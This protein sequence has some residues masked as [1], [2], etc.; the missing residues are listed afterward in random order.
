MHYLISITKLPKQSVHVSQFYFNHLNHLNGWL[1]NDHGP[2]V[3]E[4]KTLSLN[5]VELLSGHKFFPLLLSLTEENLIVIGDY[6]HYK[7]IISQNEL[8]EAQV[9]N[10]FI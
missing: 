4:L 9:K 8:F 1:V 2:L 6:V 10:A 3:L 7:I 5:N